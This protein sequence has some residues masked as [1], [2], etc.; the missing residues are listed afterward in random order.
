LLEVVEEALDQ[1]I[2]KDSRERVNELITSGALKQAEIWR[3]VKQFMSTVLLPQS[4][5]MANRARSK[6]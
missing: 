2:D 6:K 1:T 3:D 4:V 5:A